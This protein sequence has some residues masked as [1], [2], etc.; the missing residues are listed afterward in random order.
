MW[1]PELRMRL[2]ASLAML[3]VCLCCCVPWDSAQ[4]VPAGDRDYQRFKD[5]EF[6]AFNPKYKELRWE[7]KRRAVAL[8][9]RVFELESAGYNTACAHQILT[10]VKWL[11]GDTAE[12]ARTDKRLDELEKV[13]ANPDRERLADQQDLR[14][15]SWGR[16]YTEWFFKLDA[17]YDRLSDDSARNRPRLVAPRFLDRV[18]SPDKLRDYFLSVS[19]SD[20]AR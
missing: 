20:I 15:G 5:Q 3:A 2:S 11:L 18:N 17:T 10:E 12:F 14:D 6:N 8:G 4:E 13:L 7:R 1:F 9:K 19:T 16:C